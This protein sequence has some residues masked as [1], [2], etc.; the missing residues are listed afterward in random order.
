MCWR[1]SLVDIENEG[2]GFKPQPPQ[3]KK[4]LGILILIF[5]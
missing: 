4:V 1:S 5:F 2:L 3:K